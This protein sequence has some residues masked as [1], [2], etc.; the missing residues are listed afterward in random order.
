MKTKKIYV[1]RHGETQF[2]KLGMVQGSGIDAELDETGIRQAQAF[3]D[4]YAHEGFSH[5]YTSQLKR[6]IQTVKPFVDSGIP[7]TQLQGLNEICWGSREGKKAS[8]ADDKRYYRML[9]AWKEG[10]Y[11]WKIDGGESPLEVQQRQKRAWQY[12]MSRDYEEKILVCTHGRALRVL[13]CTLLN[14][15]LSKMDDFKHTNTSLYLFHYHYDSNHY[16][17]ILENDTLHL[18]DLEAESHFE[19]KLLHHI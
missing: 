17:L 4:Y 11:Y 5:I 14:L 16:D 2:N 9:R 12:I 18:A 3:Y 19:Q 6:A 7:T 15:P 8:A 13:I 10:D 1:I